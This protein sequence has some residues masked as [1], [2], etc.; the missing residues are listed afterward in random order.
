[1]PV[2]A[3]RPCRRWINSR[4]GDEFVQPPKIVNQRLQIHPVLRMV[5]SGIP[6]RTLKRRVAGCLSPSR[7]SFL[8]D[9]LRGLISFLVLVLTSKFPL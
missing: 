5:R 2:Q 7:R 6:D 9:G 4:P 1:M 8:S 3:L